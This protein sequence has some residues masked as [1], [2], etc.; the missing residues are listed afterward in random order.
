MTDGSVSM[1]AMAS[2]TAKVEVENNSLG[3]LVRGC[4]VAAPCR[5]KV[6]EQLLEIGA[7]AGLAGLTGAAVKDMADKMTSDELEHLVTLEM[8]GNDEITS[9]YLNSLQDKCGSGSASNPNIGK[10]HHG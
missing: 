8:M 7:K 4:A 9:K 3:L 1:A 5:T 6:A 2:E 10:A